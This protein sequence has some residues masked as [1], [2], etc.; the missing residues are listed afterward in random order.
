[1]A[2]GNTQ[3]IACKDCGSPFERR[4]HMGRPPVYCDTCKVKAR[5]RSALDYYHRTY[6]ERRVEPQMEFVCCDCGQRFL[7]RSTSGTR[8]RRCYECADA[9]QVN[10]LRAASLIGNAERARI[11]REKRALI[12]PETPCR[13]CGAAVTVPPAGQFS[14]RCDTCRLTH[15]RLMANRRFHL[16]QARTVA[17]YAANPPTIACSDCGLSVETKRKGGRRQRCEPCARRRQ[18]ALSRTYVPKDPE[19]WREYYRQ[20][21]YFR[22]A[23]MQ[24]VGYERFSPKEIFVRDR[25]LC[26]ICNTR[27]DPATRWPDPKSA[28]LDHIIPLSEDG[29]HSRANVR[30]AHLGCNCSRAH[31]GGNEQ[32]A[33]I[34]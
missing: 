22:R 20:R 34:G 6:P 5:R 26:G 12:G 17:D 25:W 16:R 13:D 32:L 3:P 21:G 14:R 4:T 1:M 9:L 28:T 29:P 15:R 33:L 18:K 19:K 24:G 7:R 10:R 30:A 8:P 2:D 23:R 31:R 27:I 11:N